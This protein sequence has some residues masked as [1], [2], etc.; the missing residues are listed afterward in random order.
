MG[1]LG[2]IWDA[3]TGHELQKSAQRNA[4]ASKELSQTI[5]ELS[6]EEKALKEIGKMFRDGKRNV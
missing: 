1:V 4:L 2:V 5:R 3:L 6:R